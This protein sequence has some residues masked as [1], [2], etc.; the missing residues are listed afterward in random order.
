[1]LIGLT[2][3]IY[4]GKGTIVKYFLDEGF[5]HVTISDIVKKYVKKESLEINRENLQNIGNKLREEEGP[6]IWAKKAIEE[7]DLSENY[8]L[9]GIRHPGEIE[10]LKKIKNSYLIALDAPQNIRYQRMLEMKRGIDSENWK[11]FVKT[12][13]RDYDEGTLLGF[14]VKICMRLADFMISNDSS[15][16]DFHKKIN[17]IYSQIKEN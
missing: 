8:L 2:G 16:E 13:E 3:R 1:M 11:D 15:L 9:D 5:K 7:I 14:Q 12:D 4:A 17:E 6:G 10:E